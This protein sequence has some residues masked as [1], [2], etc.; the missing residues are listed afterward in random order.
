MLP[1]LAASGCDEEDGGDEAGEPVTA[2]PATTE[3][4]TSTAAPNDDDAATSDAPATTGTS[5]T[6]DP[7]TTGE[8]SGDTA[9]TE[10]GEELVC[11]E[12]AND[13][14]G[15]PCCWVMNGCM[16]TEACCVGWSDCAPGPR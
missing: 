1:A 8:G 5:D 3:Q 7:S 14:C 11:M 9:Q 15:C 12:N 10:T 4:G 16:N 6:P 2:G 13:P